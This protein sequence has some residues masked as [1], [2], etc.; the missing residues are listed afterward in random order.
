MYSD[1]QTNSLLWT[2]ELLRL[3]PKMCQRF[4][5]SSGISIITGS[6][7]PFQNFKMWRPVQ[8]SNLSYSILCTVFSSGIFLSSIMCQFCQVFQI[9]F[10][11]NWLFQPVSRHCSLHNIRWSSC[12]ITECSSMRLSSSSEADWM[13]WLTWSGRSWNKSSASSTLNSR[14]QMRFGD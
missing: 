9:W 12:C 4:S 14:L 5:R 10:L 6:S 8:G 3:Q 11:F 2:Q 7:A 1:V 13:C